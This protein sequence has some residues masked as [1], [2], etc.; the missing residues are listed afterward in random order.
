VKFSGDNPSCSSDPFMTIAY[1]PLRSKQI[2]PSM[3]FSSIIPSRNAN[4]VLSHHLRFVMVI[5]KRF[6]DVTQSISFQ[7]RFKGAKVMT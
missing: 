6:D 7:G 4:K 2:P 5:S 1:A 3:Q